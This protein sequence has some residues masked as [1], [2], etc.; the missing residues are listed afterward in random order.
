MR[1]RRGG[2]C[3]NALVWEAQGRG[4]RAQERRA[5]PLLAFA[6]LPWPRSRGSG[7]RSFFSSVEGAGGEVV[8][9]R[10]GDARCWTL[11][12]RSQAWC[13]FARR[14]AAD[15]V[16][17]PAGRPRCPRVLRPTCRLDAGG[18]SSRA[19]LRREAGARA[20]RRR[21]AEVPPLPR[22]VIRWRLRTVIRQE[23]RALASVFGLYLPSG[24]AASARCV[25][26][27]FA[28]SPASG[29]PR[30]FPIGLGIR[31]GAAI[32]ASVGADAGASS[33]PA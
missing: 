28:E 4:P 2:P 24:C 5:R 21:V 15:R 17:G 14:R 20:A 22:L 10:G 23:D 11:R 32:A 9:T 6:T 18:E 1:E 7:P 13:A 12:I 29:S 31:Q 25:A 16:A 8:E 3:R 30:L 26:Q 19:F 27:A 33:G